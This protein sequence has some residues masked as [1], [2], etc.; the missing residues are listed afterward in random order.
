MNTGVRIGAAAIAVAVTA[1]AVWAAQAGLA[2]PEIDLKGRLYRSV[3]ISGPGTLSSGDL[4]DIAEPLRTRLSQYLARRSSFSSQYESQPAD[5]TEI[6][7]DAKRRIIERAIVSLIDATAIETRAVAFV[8]D[9]PIA[10]EWEGR[11]EGPTVEAEYAEK[12]LDATPDT[13]LAP[14]LHI[15]AAQR[16]RAA[17]EAAERLKETQTAASAEK[18]Y[19]AHL[20]MARSS[21]DPIFGLIADDLERV[22]YVYVQSSR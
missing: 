15:F 9:A 19:R 3:F 17:R 5:V 10:H 14:F 21:R 6:A 20:Q 22:P 4:A 16:Y 13:P 11:A 18:R 1:V 12:V 2:H 7:R 8:K